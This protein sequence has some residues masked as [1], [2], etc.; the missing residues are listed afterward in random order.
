[1]HFPHDSL[2]DEKYV[3]ICYNF[4]PD[5]RGFGVLFRFLYGNTQVN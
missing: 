3:N 2:S 4:E 1:M 5:L